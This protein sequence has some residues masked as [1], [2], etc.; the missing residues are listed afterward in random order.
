[1]GPHC[2]SSMGG[3]V[4]R[5]SS[6]CWWWRTS[7]V[8]VEMALED[9]HSSKWRNCSVAE[10]KYYHFIEKGK[11]FWDTPHVSQEMG[12]SSSSP[13][14]LTESED[15]PIWK[16]G[17]QKGWIPVSTSLPTPDLLASAKQGKRDFT[18]DSDTSVRGWPR[19]NVYSQLLLGPSSSRL[20]VCSTLA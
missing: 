13:R 4:R 1:M 19:E 6:P 3:S 5:A 2:I 11:H 12:E 8:F 16:S 18:K 20:L 17:G 7:P 15:A 14:T 9:K 10:G